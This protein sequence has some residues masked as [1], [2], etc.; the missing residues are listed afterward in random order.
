[1]SALRARV[2]IATPTT[3]VALLRT[4]A[5]YWQQRSVVENAETIAKAARELYDRAAV[6]QS[7][8]GG[9][10][11]NLKRAL[12]A[13]NAAVGSFNSKL[14]PMGQRLESL[15]VTDHSARQLELLETVDEAPREVDE[16]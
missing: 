9:V 15:K 10:G 6:F 11:H 1:V 16:S 13:Y 8:L 4:V 12:G 5:L 7:H 14:L 3:L 2:L